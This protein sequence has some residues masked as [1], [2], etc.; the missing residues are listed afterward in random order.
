[1]VN[2]I[3]MPN[4][5]LT[6]P[7]Y[8]ICFGKSTSMSASGAQNFVWT[9]I[10]GLSNTTG[11]MVV[12]SPTANVNYTVLGYNQG[13]T[14]TCSQVMSYSIVV[15]PIAKAS[16]S[17]SVAICD[18]AKVPLTASGGNT[19]VWTPTLG[20]NV[21]TGPGVVASPSVSTE[22]TVD[23]SYNSFCGAQKTV[24]VKVN[25]NP[26]VVAGRDTILNLEQAKFI[27]ATGTGTLTW[28][29]GSEIMCRDCPTSQVFPTATG[30]YV[31]E[32]VNEFGCKATDEMCIEITTEFGVYVPN[33]FSPNGDG[34]NDE[35]LI[36]GFN[37]TD[38]SM[39]IFNRWGEKLFSS[40]DITQGWK[41]T[42]KSQPCEVAVYVYKIT[43][44]GLDG[45][46]YNKTGHITLN[47]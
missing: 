40:K 47:R 37:I 24:F 30:C 29:N 42:F 5:T 9:P 13:G 3:P 16:V 26:T 46:K 27:N 2:V 45:K 12:A 23:V 44:K 1:L 6:S 7:E 36:S 17:N 41:G 15:I 22:Y 18:G 38:I 31:V 14:V 32:A 39:D 21:G 8:Q 20:L 34:V 4:L 33:A 35:F 11:S 43:Y 10:T 19:I 28:I 25:P